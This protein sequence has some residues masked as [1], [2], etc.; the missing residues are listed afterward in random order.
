[1]DLETFSVLLLLKKLC[2][3]EG[4]YAQPCNGIIYFGF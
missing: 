3:V 2:E 1:M 4:E